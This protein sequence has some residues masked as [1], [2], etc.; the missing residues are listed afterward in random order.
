MISFDVLWGIS[1]LPSQNL[2]RVPAGVNK[3]MPKEATMNTS[4]L[5]K[6]DILRIPK[7][8]ETEDIEMEDK[9]IHAK[10]FTP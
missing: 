8:Y 3:E 6:S 10:F 7:L 1:T 9:M 5:T 4:L 2:C